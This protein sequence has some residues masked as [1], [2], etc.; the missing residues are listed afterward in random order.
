[1]LSPSSRPFITASVPILREQG[2]AIAGTFYTRL[3]AA[4][5]ELKNVFNLGNQ[6]S[7]A[8]RQALSDAL[9]A[10]AAHIDSA[11]ALAPVLSRIAHKHAAVGVKPAHYPIVA[12]HLLAAIAEV[13]GEAA[14]PALL[15]AWD[16]AYWLLAGE[17]I[18]AEARLYE[19]AQT[20]AGDLHS[21]VVTRVTRESPSVSAYRLELPQ[22]GSPGSFAPGQYVTVAVDLPGGLR[23]LRQY[24][25][26]DAPSHPYWR[27]A[28]KREAG[29]PSFP[30]G[31]VS[32]HLHQALTQ[33]QRLRVSPAFGDFTPLTNAPPHAP[34]VLL[35]AGIG[36]T[37]MLSVLQTLAAERSP[38]AVLFVHAVRAA[39]E[40][41]FSAELSE[42]HAHMSQL[43]SGVFIEHGE[44]PQPSGGGTTLRS[45]RLQLDPALLRG[46]E[47][48]V[49]YLCGPEPFMR[50]QCRALVARGVSPLRIE[51][52][53]F[54]P[55][56][57]E[58]LR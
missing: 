20:H 57:L 29:S 55:A 36:I 41:L 27:I 51:R 40:R 17:L 11:Q 26:C 32:T 46:F 48:A 56:M 4:H 30:E 43:R 1:M 47:D 2:P 53:V 42:A 37:P 33:G 18:A 54:G 10:Y 24:S 19:R 21:L 52:E 5:P 38:R 9:I 15:S 35:S 23:Q 7:G 6:E 3:F 39:D 12:R 16:E 31:R 34:L 28:V 14:S 44:L 13:L 22:G 25:L 50:E 8:Q 49:F 45:G 58:H